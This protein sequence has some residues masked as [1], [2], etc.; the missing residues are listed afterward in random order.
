MAVTTSSG[1]FP[2]EALEL[3]LESLVVH[4]ISSNEIEAKHDRHRIPPI[5]TLLRLL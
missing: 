5:A 2:T 1:I 4:G 3:A